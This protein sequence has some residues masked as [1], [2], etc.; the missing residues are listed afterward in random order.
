MYDPNRI[1][2]IARMLAAVSLFLLAPYFDSPLAADPKSQKKG[3][4]PWWVAARTGVYSFQSTY[5]GSG[6]YMKPVDGTPGGIGVGMKEGS[7]LGAGGGR[8]FNRWLGAEASLSRF[9]VEI[10]GYDLFRETGET[11]D[12]KIG[13]GSV[14]AIQAT[15]LFDGRLDFG[16]TDL[17]QLQKYRF[18]Y[19]LG[20]DLIYLLPD[21]VVLSKP[22]RSR[23]G[24]FAVETRPAMIFGLSVRGDIR[25]GRGP[26]AVTL[27]GTL[28]FGGGEPFEVH[29]D[30]AVGYYSTEVSF[31]PLTLTI[32]FMRWF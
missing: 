23:L 19:Y 26:W 30:P 4:G 6:G 24:V 32:G 2:P 13:T 20:V 7:F 1:S 17:N 18:I 25:V 16:G 29:T 10:G 8:R 28:T 9:D 12:V 14:T 3:M 15:V 21:D 31:H 5:G 27:N 11:P 22:G